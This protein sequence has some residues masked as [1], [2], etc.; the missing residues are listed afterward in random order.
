MWMLSWKL[1]WKPD[2]EDITISDVQVL[3]EN[4]Q[5]NEINPT[6]NYLK[7]ND[8]IGKIWQKQQRK[9]WKVI[10]NHMWILS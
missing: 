10:L 5:S 7:N 6:Q 9:R 2:K 3:S 4:L 8:N 1:A